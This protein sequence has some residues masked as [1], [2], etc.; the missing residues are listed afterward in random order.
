MYEIRNRF[1]PELDSRVSEIFSEFTGGKYDKLY[2]QKDYQKIKDELHSN[3]GVETVAMAYPTGVYNTLA[4]AIL[5]QEGIKVTFSVE[6]GVN[7]VVK[8]L[9]QSLYSLKRFNM[10]EGMSLLTLLSKVRK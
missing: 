1:G 9:P 10:T 8:G 7:E 5:S 3:L 2:V 4:N 6:E